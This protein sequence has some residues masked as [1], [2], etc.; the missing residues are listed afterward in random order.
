M[1][2][3]SL[4]V[5]K[6][7]YFVLTGHNGS[8]KTI[9]IKIITGIYRPDSGVVRLGGEIVNDIPPWKRNIGYVPQEGLLFFNRSVR[10][11][12]R[13]GLEVRKVDESSVVE[14]V[15][16]VAELLNITHLMDRPVTGLS[17]GER[18]RVA[19]ARAL[20]FEPRVLL[21]DEPVS[22]IDENSR[23]ELCREL[24]RI[25]RALGITVLHVAHA[26]REI[27]LVADRCGRIEAGRMQRVDVISG[28][29]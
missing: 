23:D 8:G 6:G 2:D 27:D 11:N 19:L 20:A 26:Q 25:Q 14:R 3:L 29:P 13:F 10:D 16:R 5:R 28:N 1:Q 18:Q 4:D 12:I 22:A 9:I 24:R 21:L 7:E 17:G 15:D